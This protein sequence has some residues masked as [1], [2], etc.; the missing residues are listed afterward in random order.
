[1]VATP[2]SV[3]LSVRAGRWRCAVVREQ[4]GH[5]AFLD[6]AAP[7]AD[8]TGR[9][10]I[11]RELAALFGEAV[12]GAAG[13]RQAIMITLRRRSVGLLVD[14]IDSL[15]AADGSA[16]QP[17]SP[18]LARRMA[19]PWFLGAIVCDDLPL[20]L[21]DLRRIATDVAAGAISPDI[22]M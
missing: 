18:I 16:V 14:H 6:P 19:R 7:P 1:M 3:F 13:R 11:C 8:P 10:L 20:L 4:V 5:L 17:L 15:E 22:P 2:D 12:V 21:L 9:P